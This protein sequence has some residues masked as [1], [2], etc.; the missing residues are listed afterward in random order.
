MAEYTIEFAA[1]VLEEERFWMVLFCNRSRMRAG[2]ET[3]TRIRNPP[4]RIIIVCPADFSKLW[5]SSTGQVKIS[6]KPLENCG[7]SVTTIVRNCP[8]VEWCNTSEGLQSICYIK[9]IWADALHYLH[10][11]QHILTTPHSHV[12]PSLSLDVVSPPLISGPTLPAAVPLICFQRLNLSSL[13]P[14]IENLVIRDANGEFKFS[15]DYNNMNILKIILQIIKKHSP[16]LSVRYSDHLS[17]L[18]PVNKT[19]SNTISDDIRERNENKD[20]IGLKNQSAFVSVEYKDG[21]RKQFKAHKP[22]RKHI[23]DKKYKMHH[24]EIECMREIEKEISRNRNKIKLI[25]LVSILF[26]CDDCVFRLAKLCDSHPIPFRNSFFK[27]YKDNSI[28]KK[29]KR[30]LKELEND[31]AYVSMLH[32]LKTKVKLEHSKSE[33]TAFPNKSMKKQFTKSIKTAIPGENKGLFN[34]DCSIN[35]PSNVNI[36]EYRS[37]GQ[38]EADKFAEYMRNKGVSDENCKILFCK[39]WN[40]QVENE[41]DK[42]IDDKIMDYFIVVFNKLTVE[43]IKAQNHHFNIHRIEEV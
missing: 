4:P 6:S 26:F 16:D 14:S 12:Y 3:R 32:A 13:H 21:T 18:F 34:I 7:S 37:C 36:D 2:P 35:Y 11:V 28:V 5:K 30:D 19:L 10:T 1:I 9:N 24:S 39:M 33:F 29:I 43:S 41:F 40:E 23:C 25:D 17:L 22:Q 27:I 8:S 20:K 42:F 31:P 38:R 15:E